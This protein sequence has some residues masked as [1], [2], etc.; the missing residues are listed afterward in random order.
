MRQNPIIPILR[1][2]EVALIT[3]QVGS[4]WLFV[5]GTYRGFDYVDDGERG[6]RRP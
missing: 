5:P 1:R 6:G 4:R 2:A 3:S